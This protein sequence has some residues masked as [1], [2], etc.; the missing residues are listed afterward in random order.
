MLQ[1]VVSKPLI[2]RRLQAQHTLLESFMARR[3]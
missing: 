2:E 1:W 3:K